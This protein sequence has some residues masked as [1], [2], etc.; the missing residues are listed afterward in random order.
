[1]NVGL[2]E[3]TRKL[4]EEPRLGEQDLHA[5]ILRLVE[6]EYVCVNCSNIAA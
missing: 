2:Q 4:L 5:K 3:R 1:M 6:A